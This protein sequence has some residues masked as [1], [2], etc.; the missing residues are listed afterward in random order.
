MRIRTQIETMVLLKKHMRHTTGNNLGPNA[1]QALQQQRHEENLHR[2]RYEAYS[3]TSCELLA[4]S[5]F[6]SRRLQSTLACPRQ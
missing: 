5:S 3:G 2:H 1:P 6:G 4:A